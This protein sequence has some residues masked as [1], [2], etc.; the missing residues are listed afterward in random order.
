[1]AC[2]LALVVGLFIGWGL[3]RS[4]RPGSL[5][6]AGGRRQSAAAHN[7]AQCIKVLDGDTIRVLWQGTEE[8]VRIL[9]IDCPETRNGKKLTE[10]SQTLHLKKEYV[11][12]YGKIAKKTTSSWLLNRDVSLVFPNDEVKRDSFGRLLCYVEDQGVDIG[13]RLL[14]GGN[15]FLWDS[16]HPRR[17]TYQLLETE[18]QRQK[19]GVWRK[20][21]A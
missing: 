6:G 15:A 20:R 8:D 7:L 5:D 9:G 19:K 10:Q 13:E 3:S 11:L 4:A 1:M 12:N 17:D 2:L 16:E 14:A 18:A 21:G